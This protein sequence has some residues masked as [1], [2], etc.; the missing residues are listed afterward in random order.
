MAFFDHGGVMNKSLFVA[1]LAILECACATQPGV[2]S[3]DQD[4]ISFAEFAGEISV[5]HEKMDAN[6]VG[7]ETAAYIVIGS[8]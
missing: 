5:V 8:P 1:A 6:D 2:S 3:H 4:L 7:A